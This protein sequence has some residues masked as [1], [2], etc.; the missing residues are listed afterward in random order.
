MRVGRRLAVKL[1]NAS[2]FAL[3]ELPP[4]GPELTHVLD[5]AL[6]GRLAEV[7]ADATRQLEEYEYTRAL[8]RTESFFW[9]YCD[10]YIELVK[11]RRYA[12]EAGAAASVSRAL[13]LSL[14]ALQRLFAPFLPFVAE[15]VWSWWQPGSVH[16]AP[17]PNVQEL[18]AP[19]G[20]SAREEEALAVAA[21]VLREVRKAKSD[22]HRKMRA[23]VARVLV[24]DRAERLLALQMGADDLRHA[25]VVEALETRNADEFSV[26]VEL[27]EEA[28]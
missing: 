1:L 21:D 23:P 11:G 2:K 22:A 14:S 25:G 15:E 5:R 12:T 4:A 26:E 10:Y 13:R 8:E 24:H 16:R 6:V 17:W 18:S 9:F 7:V 20:E 3:A 19:S 27:A 28:A